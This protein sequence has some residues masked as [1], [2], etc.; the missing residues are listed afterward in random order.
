MTSVQENIDFF[1]LPLEEFLDVN[2]LN[3]V[4]MVGHSLGGYLCA[5]HALRFPERLKTLT[6][7]SPVGV[8]QLPTPKDTIQASNLPLPY[9]FIDAAWANNV[10]PQQLI[11]L[12]GPRGPRV[13]SSIMQRRFQNRWE[14]AL[15]EAVS[16]YVHH[17]SAQKGSGEYAMN[18]LLLPVIT[19]EGSKSSAGVYA[20]TPLS[21]A[22]GVVVQQVPTMAI[23]GDHDWMLN[24]GVRQAAVSLGPQFKLEVVPNAGHH[25]YM[26]NAEHFHQLVIDHCRSG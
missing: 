12:L 16:S 17:I 3:D 11:R 5:M 7:V 4:H 13:V 15:L 1:T 24:K 14:P 22:L 25:L 26:D 2:G 23:F 19:A 6:L 20:R 18:S 9:R 8:P 10:T 21:D